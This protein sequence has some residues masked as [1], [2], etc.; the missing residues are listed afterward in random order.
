MQRRVR[1]ESDSEVRRVRVYAMAA[2]AL[3]I[4]LCDLAPY[5]L[6]SK[7]VCKVCK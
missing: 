2:A 3:I 5:A 1:A 4:Y 6:C 7:Q